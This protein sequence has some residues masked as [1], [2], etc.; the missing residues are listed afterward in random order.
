MVGSTFGYI[1]LGWFLFLQ[2]QIK[3]III[4]RG[5]DACR[6]VGVCLVSG[7]ALVDVLLDIVP[8]PTHS[9]S[10]WRR[11]SPARMGREMGLQE[12]LKDI[13]ITPFFLADS[14][15]LPVGW[16]SC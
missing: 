8:L 16:V 14:G 5:G 12:Q 6:A 4:V 10:P 11:A 3:D 2:E 13:I 1:P 7:A 9:F 15:G